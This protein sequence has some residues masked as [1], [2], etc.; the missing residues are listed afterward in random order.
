MMK[1]IV[2]IIMLI[3]FL[4]VSTIPTIQVVKADTLRDYKNK[5]AELENK[6]DTTDRLSAE[7][8]QKIKSK[9]NAILQANN[10]ISANETKVENSKQLVSESREKIKIKTEELKDVIKV[11]QYTQINKDE[12]Y[13]DFVFSSSSIS[14][15]MERQAII[16][17][18]ANH[19]Q[20]ELNNLD[21]L[22]KQNQKLQTQLEKDNVVLTNSITSYEEQV[23]ALQEEINELATVGL[24]YA[25]QIEAQKGL[26]K[27]YEAAGCK[28]NDD[29][30]DCYYAK[31]NASGSFSRPLT[32]GK[33][34]Q[35]WKVNSSGKITHAGIDLG[36][37]PAGTNIYAPA[38][39]TIVYTKH[40]YK[41]GGNIIYMH[42]VVDGKKYTIELAHLKSIKVKI[43]DVVKKGQVIATQGGDSSTW[44][45]DTC[46]SG[47]HLH[48][49]ISNGYYFT[50]ATW[51]GFYTFQKNT[52]AT[53]IQSISG[54]KNQRGW[55]WTTRG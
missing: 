4:V 41:C 47:T 24:D 18:I 39:G 51:N 14:E 9:R 26:I 23:I 5:V 52:K 42:S 36:G 55:T 17:Q 31:I 10:T 8:A 49:A 20:E 37:V 33:V 3:S 6:K 38:N 15:M 29:I 19:T 46:T 54:L 43:G 22:I 13:T 40:K 28:D 25:S 53:S 44:Y 48:Y 45:Y 7:A 12:I 35:P 21:S 16:E 27:I 30:D 34:T 32:K 50:D 2:S 1:K 11:M